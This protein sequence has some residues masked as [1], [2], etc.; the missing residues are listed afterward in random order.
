[1]TTAQES[2]AVMEE[3]SLD[4]TGLTAGHCA[5]VGLQ[6]GDEGKGQIVDMLAR[7]FDLVAR[8]N[9]GANAGHSVFIPG[10]EQK[11]ALHLIPSGI[12]YPDKIN[13]VG[14]GVVLDP[15]KI[16][17]E[18]DGLRARG[19]KVGENLR[20]SN[21]AHVV[22]PYHKDEDK[23]REESLAQDKGEGEK[24]GTTGRGIGPCYADKAMRATAIRVADLY[25]EDELRTKLRYIVKIKNAMLGGLCAANGAKPIV[26]DADELATLALGWAKSIA[27]H[28]C[29][30]G[31]LLHDAIGGGKK[32]L[33]EGANATL[34]DIDHGTY[35]YVTSS[36]CSSLGIYPGTGVPGGTLK[37]A[38][39]IVKLY[40]SRVGSGPFPTEIHDATAERI[41][42]V[43]REYGT[44]TGRP[45]R[46]GWLDLVAMRYTAAINGVT[47]IA[48]TGLS[49]LAGL[50]RIK[51][52]VGYRY[53]G[54]ELDSF[55]ADAAVLGGVEPILKEF[56]GFPAPIDSCRTFDELPS[57]ARTY[58][59]FIESRIGVP[60][61]M[62]CVG[63]RRDQILTR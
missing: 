55:P 2:S 56:E 34:L 39:G 17:E 57:Q 20:I 58:I 59:S 26:Y 24:L 54:R 1:M 41:R 62:V 28:V 10:Q 38:V 23:L 44:T 48:C 45:R 14:N 6:W 53:K 3:D 63:R 36:S 25:R 9:G 7:R 8:Y 37:N 32:I 42:E 47:A 40:T 35:P 22:F 61:R 19:V 51:V 16:L 31:K 46:V 30:T 29:D 12:L 18:I 52:C 27:P 5:V 60:I 43:G 15:A 13:I 11:F 4:S 49:V 33:F 21:R 50:E